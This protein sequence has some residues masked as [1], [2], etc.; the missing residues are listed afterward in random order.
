MDR[1]PDLYLPT[2]DPA[3]F[4]VFSADAVTV[5]A[6]GDGSVLC[7]LH[8]LEALYNTSPDLRTGGTDFSF[9]KRFHLVPSAK[10]LVT[11]PRSDDRLVLRR[12]DLDAAIGRLEKDYLLVLSPNTVLAKAGETLEHQIVAR[13]KS[14][15]VR[16]ELVEGPAGLQ[17]QPD[18]K[19]TFLVPDSLEGGEVTALI[20]ASDG[21]GLKRFHKLMIRS[22]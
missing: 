17:V 10:L 19:V 3:Y 22:R 8:G 21:S 14:G 16:F 5:R 15:K 11:I 18:G 20:T 2:T 7:T 9:E 12:I 1:I 13:S 6:S 4:L